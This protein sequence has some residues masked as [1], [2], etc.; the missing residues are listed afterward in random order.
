MRLYLNRPGF[1]GGDV[2]ALVAKGYS[3]PQAATDL[4]VSRKAIEYY[5]RNM[6]GE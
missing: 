4:S 2:A 6:Y 5:L 3:D 1:P